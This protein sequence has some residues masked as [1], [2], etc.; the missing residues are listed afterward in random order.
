[1]KRLLPSLLLLTLSDYRQRVE[2]WQTLLQLNSSPPQ[3]WIDATRPVMIAIE[4]RLEV[5][6]GLTNLQSSVVERCAGVRCK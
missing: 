6:C 1:M 4:E 5:T 2:Y 3:P